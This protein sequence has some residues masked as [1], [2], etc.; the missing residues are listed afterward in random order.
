M[1][2]PQLFIKLTRVDADTA[3][4]TTFAILFDG[5]VV[6]SVEFKDPEARLVL[7]FL[8]FLLGYELFERCVEIAT[9]LDDLND[10][11]LLCKLVTAS[12]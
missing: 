8:P 10:V 1:E 7:N 2:R 12:C 6:L 11:C 4:F 3:F 9:R 5:L